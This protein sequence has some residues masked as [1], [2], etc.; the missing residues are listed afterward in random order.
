M[1]RNELKDFAKS[2]LRNHYWKSVLIMIIVYVFTIAEVFPLAL[3]STDSI[4]DFRVKFPSNKLADP[5]VTMVLIVLIIC[6]LILAIAI[7]VFFTVFFQNPINIGASKYLLNACENKEA[8]VS[9][10]CF[11]FDHNYLNG[12]KAMFIKQLLI[13]LYSI[14]LIIPG[15]IKIYEY[16]FVEFILCENPTLEYKEALLQSKNLMNGNKKFALLFDL[17]FIPLQ[18]LDFFTFGLLSIF[19]IRPYRNLANAKLYLQLKEKEM[20]A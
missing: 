7:T 17:S 10:V 12:V 6:T 15:I 11:S 19:Y 13:V 3:Q 2:I 1:N 5:E 9:D 8:N 16:R 20:N 18:I 4:L 14:A